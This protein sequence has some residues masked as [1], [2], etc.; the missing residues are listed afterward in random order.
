VIALK[1]FSA[2]FEM[3]SRL[4]KQYPWGAELM[5]QYA[6]LELDGGMWHLLTDV[7]SKHNEASRKW[8]D[9]NIAIEE[10]QQEGWTVAG[11]YPNWLSRKPKINQSVHG[12]G[13]IRTFH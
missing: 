13:L 3:K 2:I 12:Y 8:D 11:S 6:W 7:R 5:S 9:K 1:N 4:L 10:S